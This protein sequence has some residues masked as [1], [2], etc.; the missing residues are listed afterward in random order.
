MPLRASI[1]PSD[2]RPIYVQIMD[3][4]RRAIALGE[5]VPD[6]PLP[7]ARQLAQEL[8]LN[9]LTVKQAYG[10]LEREGVVYVRRGLGTYVARGVSPASERRRLAV[11]VARRAVKEALRHGF[12]PEEFHA[13]VAEAAA[14]NGWTSPAEEHAGSSTA[15]TRSGD[16]D[17]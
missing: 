3:E 10:G 6:E 1:D 15:G 5:M 4:V 16:D 17:A 9:H 8:T 14:E 12:S 7:S 2:L 11:E 13:A